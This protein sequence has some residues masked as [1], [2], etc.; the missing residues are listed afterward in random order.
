ME[1]ISSIGTPPALVELLGH[2]GISELITQP[3]YEFDDLGSAPS[4]MTER[5]GDRLSGSSLKAHLSGNDLIFEQ[6]HIFKQQTHHAFAIPIEVRASFH[7]R[8]K[9]SIR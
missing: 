3:V 4:P 5:N 2:L 8:G 1:Q 9:S 6:G 7:T